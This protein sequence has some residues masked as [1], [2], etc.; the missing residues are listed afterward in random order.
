MTMLLGDRLQQAIFERL[1]ADTALA[2]LLTGVYDEVPEGTARPYLTVGDT[3][4]EDA[5]TKDRAATTITFTLFVWTDETGQMQA[6]EL[7]AAVDDCLSRFVPHV[8]GA[9]AGELVLTAAATTRQTEGARAQAQ[10]R[11]SY[12]VKLYEE[13]LDPRESA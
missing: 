5:S 1:R 8:P 10:A 2:A 7:M 13:A 4:F 11:M 3:T 6:K 12:R 9:E